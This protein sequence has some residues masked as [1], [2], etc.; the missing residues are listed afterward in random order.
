MRFF[1]SA[2]GDVGSSWNPGSVGGKDSVSGISKIEISERL[3]S[4]QVKQTKPITPA[5]RM[6]NANSGCLYLKQRFFSQS[7]QRNVF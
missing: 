3:G 5:K 4:N 1:L 7:Q 6:S 2:P